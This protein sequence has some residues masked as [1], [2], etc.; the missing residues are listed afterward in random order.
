MVF[1]GNDELKETIK[2]K[3]RKRESQANICNKQLA[4]IETK[5]GR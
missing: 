4:S 2:H 1:V 3:E 5:I